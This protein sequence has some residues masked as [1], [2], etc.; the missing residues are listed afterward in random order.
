MSNKKFYVTTSIMYTNSPPHIG[1]AFESIQADVIA[2]YHRL[3]GEDT[4]FLTGTD[5]HGTKVAKAAIEAGKNSK[6]FVDEIA[7]KV[8]ELKEVL[9]LSNDDFI[10]TTDQKRHWPAVKKVWLKLKEAGDIY[11]KKYQAF[12][13]SGCEAFITKKDLINEKCAIHQTE[14][15]I[16]DEENYFFK[17]SKYAKTIEKAIEKDEMKVIPKTRENEILS[18]IKQGLEDVSFSRPR[19]KLRWGIPVPDDETQTLYVWADALT[20]YISAIGYF[21]ETEQFKKFWPADVHCIGKDITRFH[22]VI[23]PGMLLSLELPLPKTIFVHG[24]ITVGGQ[25]MS[26]SLGNII[27]PFE[28]VKKYSS[29][30]S[31]QAGTD[32]VRYF[33]LREIPSTEDGDFTYEKFEKRYN[34]DLAAGLGNLVARVLTMVEKYC[35]GK[36][37]KIDKDPDSHPLRIDLKIHNWK[38]S[39]ADIDKYLPNF[40]FNDALASIW[41]FIAEADKYIEENKPWD[42]AKEGKIEELD[43]VLYGL[44]DAIHQLAWQ[45][46]IFLPDTALKIA[47]ALRLEKILVRNPN[48][49][50]SWTNMKPGTKIKKIEP[51][52]PKLI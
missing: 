48:Y 34:S 19:E 17:L 46:F 18:F 4:F 8:R 35:N 42:L 31:P 40:Q 50:D 49:K 22:A 29:A 37:P 3:L 39:W 26:K 10:R 32:A 41:K 1:F 5:E 51:L 36:V 15:E 24:F 27:N 20:N 25:K 47:G 2:R 16:I 11:K 6:E 52:F 33:L 13:C 28:L 12:Y 9:N 14:P 23:W 45:I 7:G 43:W 30:G 44:L 21:E 38:K